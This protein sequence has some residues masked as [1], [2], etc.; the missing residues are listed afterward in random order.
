MDWQAALRARLVAAAPVTALVGQRIYWVDRPQGTALPAITLQT[1]N[2]AR[3]QHLKGFE[4]MQQARVQ[5]DVWA[6][7]YASARDITE[8]VIAALIAPDENNGIQFT[9]AMI[10]GLRDLSERLETQLIYRSS[11]DFIFHHA[12]A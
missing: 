5:I 11:V 10:D 4:G 2:D 12:T 8:A 9:R 3:D 6:A 7:S 1:I